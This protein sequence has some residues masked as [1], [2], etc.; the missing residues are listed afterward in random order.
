MVKILFEEVTFEGREGKAVTYKK[1][2]K[3]RRKRIPDL[4]SRRHDHYICYLL[5]KVG[6]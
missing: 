4:C 2:K 6:M 5:L 3:K 1:K